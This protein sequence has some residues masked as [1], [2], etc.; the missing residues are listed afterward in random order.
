MEWR[1]GQQSLTY[2]AGYNPREFQM[3]AT[4]SK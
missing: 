3:A 1:E 2:L 4:R